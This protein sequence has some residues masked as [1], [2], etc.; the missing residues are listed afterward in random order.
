MTKNPDRYWDKPWS[1]VDGCTPWTKE[2][3]YH[4]SRGLVGG[5]GKFT[6]Q[7]ITHPERLNIPLT[8]RKPTVYAIWNDLF[9]GDVP[10]SFIGRVYS[11]ALEVPRHTFL[12]LTK[13]PGRMA[14]VTTR[15]Y[16]EV[17]AKSLRQAVNIWN[18]LTICNQEEW[19][20][21]KK[22]FSMIPGKK[23]LSLEP[24]LG[25]IDLELTKVIKE[26]FFGWPDSEME[27][28]RK[29]D[30]VI[31]GGETGPG[32]RPMHPDWVRSVRDQC[33]VAGVPFFFKQWGEWGE[34]TVNGRDGFTSKHYWLDHYWLDET[35][36]L[37]DQSDAPTD[38]CVCV[39]RVGKKNVGRCLDGRTHD[40]LPWRTNAGA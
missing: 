15:F 24:M 1:L 11:K 13:R 4:G 10:D 32:A 19:N 30:A 21:K 39:K 29:I 37:H 33:A 14:D 35:G 3:E 23:F 28:K 9:H 2:K 27:Y 6:G 18:G 7:V 26:P 12:I 38:D 25:A 16:V 34:F 31:L 40:Y 17:D 22:Y 8:R 36:T 5:D 20:E